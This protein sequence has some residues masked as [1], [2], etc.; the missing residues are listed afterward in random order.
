MKGNQ[1]KPHLSNFK[2]KANVGATHGSNMSKWLKANNY[3]IKKGPKTTQGLFKMLVKK[4]LDAALANQVVS[5][6]FF[7]ISNIEPNIFL[8][9]IMPK[10]YLVA[11]LV[12]EVFSALQ[13]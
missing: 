8:I 5:E 9:I 10:L 4:R 13:M 6:Y 3:K 12:A 7:K 2:G 11:Y 1:L